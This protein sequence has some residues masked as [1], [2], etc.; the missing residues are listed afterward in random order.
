MVRAP[1]ATR[2]STVRGT[3]RGGPGCCR[4]AGAYSNTSI[5]APRP[6]YGATLGDASCTRAS[7]VAKEATRNPSATSRQVPSRRRTTAHPTREAPRS[8]GRGSGL[9]GGGKRVGS[10]PGDFESQLGPGERGGGL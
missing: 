4:N 1:S 5:Q 8:P 6:V 2:S 9:G 10:D 7:A 3:T